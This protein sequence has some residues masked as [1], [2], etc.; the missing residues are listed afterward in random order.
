M[1]AKNVRKNG[2]D[3]HKYYGNAILFLREIYLLGVKKVVRE[4]AL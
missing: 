4:A 2:M 1:S 3:F